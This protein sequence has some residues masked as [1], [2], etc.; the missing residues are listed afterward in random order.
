M[1]MF[2]VYTMCDIVYTKYQDVSVKAVEQVEFPVY[3]LPMQH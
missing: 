1:Q 3:A 2:N